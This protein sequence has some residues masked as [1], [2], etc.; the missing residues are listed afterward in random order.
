MKAFVVLLVFLRTLNTEGP[1]VSVS[2]TCM[3]TVNG[4]SRSRMASLPRVTREDSVHD[5]RRPQ[6]LHILVVL[7]LT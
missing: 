6:V 3:S 2:V 7:D 1:M 5:A 4:V